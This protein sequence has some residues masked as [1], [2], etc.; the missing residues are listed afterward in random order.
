M[1]RIWII[2]LTL[3][4][5]PVAIHAQEIMSSENWAGVIM[6][7]TQ[8][9]NIGF[10][11]KASKDGKYTGT[12]DVPAQGAKNIPVE[13]T[14]N[15]GDSLCISIT[16]LRAAYKGRK[17]S[18]ESIEGRFTQNEMTFPLNM[19]PGKVELN[20][21]QTPEPPYPYATEEVVFKNE[22]EGATL[23]GTLTYP[24]N[25]L[26]V[27]KESVP[28][29]LFVTGSGGQDRNEEIFGHKPFLVI[30][31]YLAKRGIASLR[32]DDRGVGK[33][34]GPTQGVT[35][36]N[37]LADAEA[38][39]AFL[40]SLNKFGKVG[41]IGHS[42]GGTIAF[43]LGAKKSVDFLVSLAGSAASGLEVIIGQNKAAMQLQGLPPMVI[44]DYAK[45][46][47]ILYKD[48]VARKQIANQEQYIEN[49]C[50][51][52][53]LSLP[54]NFKANLVQCI[55]AG[56]EWITWFLGYHPSEAIRQIIC[57]TMALNGTLDL[58]VLSKDN[59]PV[60][61][62]NL[63]HNEKHL[64]KEYDS[65]NHLFQRCTPVTALNYGGIEETISEEV[66]RDVADWILDI[67]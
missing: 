19:K 40:R 65:L 46:L 8:K 44:E 12:M 21:P 66:L 53:S 9:L 38:G 58:Q 2:L 63:P 17:A 5:F 57:P 20:R 48:R 18:P 10:K 41:V 55:T 60:I 34:T 43:M 22:A 37:N 50:K 33:S 16:A 56:G 64:I 24:I 67:K 30:A 45:A 13:I 36:M 29:V 7:G 14:K 23:S 32:Y 28:V 39:I 25:Y 52:H 1:K 47:D 61:K 35:T 62:A 54:A 42:E 3:V 4:S 15:D 26:F 51:N 59:L 11:V 27:P 49:L 6:L 31:D